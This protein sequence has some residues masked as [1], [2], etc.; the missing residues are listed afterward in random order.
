MFIDVFCF[1]RWLHPGSYSQ[2]SLLTNQEDV[3]D[4]FISIWMTTGF[5]FSKKTIDMSTVDVELSSPVFPRV[6]SSDFLLFYTCNLNYLLF[7]TIDI[8]T[9]A[10]KK[11]SFPGLEIECI[12]IIQNNWGIFWKKIK[13]LECLILKK[14]SMKFNFLRWL[15]FL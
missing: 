5:F 9:L 4:S 11:F 7:L 15:P 8:E 6:W 1:Y 14:K 2:F 10:E 13:R 3:I 12:A